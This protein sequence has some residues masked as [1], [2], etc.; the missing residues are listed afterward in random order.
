MATRLVKV[1]QSKPI[2]ISIPD[3]LLEQFEKVRGDVSRIK[4]TDK[5]AYRGTPDTYESP[6]GQSFF[7]YLGMSEKVFHMIRL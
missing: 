6:H 2:T 1:K 3:D 7:N 5:T 4:A